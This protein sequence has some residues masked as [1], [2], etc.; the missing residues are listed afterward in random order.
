MNIAVMGKRYM[1]KSTL[2]RFLAERIQQRKNAH[3]IIA[4]D[5]KRTF[6]TVPHTSDIAE[7]EVLLTECDNRM[8]SYQ[9]LEDVSEKRGMDEE[10]NLFFEAIGIEYHLGY[11]KDSSRLDLRPI[12]LIVDEASF[13]Q[14]G[15]YINPNLARLIRLADAHNFFLIQ[16][17]HRPTDFVRLSRSQFEEVYSFRQTLREDLDVIRV[18]T[19]EETAEIISRLPDHHVVRY[20]LDGNEREI[21]SQPDNWYI[22]N[23]AD[24]GTA[25]NKDGRSEAA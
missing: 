20:V 4:F 25:S 16:T 12:V 15:Q 17:S 8:V 11:G 13:L 22:D 7:L 1:G 19:D 10:F 2:A 21:W 6:R 3:T 5:P 24:N 9:P 14:A 23:G 18:W